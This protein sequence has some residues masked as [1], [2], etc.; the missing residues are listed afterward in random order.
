LKAVLMEYNYI[1]GVRITWHRFI[2][3]S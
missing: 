2:R 1:Q 3:S